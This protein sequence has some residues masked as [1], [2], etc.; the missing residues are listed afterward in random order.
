MPFT[1]ATVQMLHDTRLSSRYREDV[2]NEGEVGG[3]CE[4]KFDQALLKSRAD[5]KSPLQSWYST[6]YA[7]CHQGIRK[8]DERGMDFRAAELLPFESDPD[9]K[10]DK[11]HCD[12]IFDKPTVA[13]KLDAGIF[14]RSVSVWRIQTEW[15]FLQP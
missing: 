8:C 2:I 13:F 12:V 15:V 9:F 3:F 10:V 1:L 6:T 5:H 4:T 14:S 7:I 11:E